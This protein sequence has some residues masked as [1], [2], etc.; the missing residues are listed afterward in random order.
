MGFKEICSGVLKNSVRTTKCSSIS[1]SQ[2]TGVECGLR[3][4]RVRNGYVKRSE[5]VSV[6][7]I[8]GEGDVWIG[9]C[10]VWTETARGEEWICEEN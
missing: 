9:D 3:L 5:C 4:P 2:K 1:K 7:G 10:R 8:I 6:S